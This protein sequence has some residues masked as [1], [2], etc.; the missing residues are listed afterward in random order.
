MI[1][2]NDLLKW[3]KVAIDAQKSLDKA[4]AANST[5]MARSGPRGGKA[6]TLEAR[7]Q[8]AA[9]YMDDVRRHLEKLVELAAKDGIETRPERA[10]EEVRFERPL[11]SHFG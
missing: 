10:G 9:E 7:H 1:H 5:A 11:R 8:S 4:S 3:S 6:T 2:V